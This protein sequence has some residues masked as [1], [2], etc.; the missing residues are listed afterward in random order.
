MR[1]RRLVGLNDKNPI[2]AIGYTANANTV[3]Q[4]SCRTALDGI[5]GSSAVCDWNHIHTIRIVEG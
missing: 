1:L 2:D 4:Y 3:K 5:I